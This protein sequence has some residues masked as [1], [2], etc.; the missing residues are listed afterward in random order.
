MILWCMLAFLAFL[1][2]WGCANL[3]HRGVCAI[4][5]PSSKT[6]KDPINHQVHVEQRVFCRF[7]L[8]GNHIIIITH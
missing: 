1:M 5:R 4:H 8:D 7:R 2:L 3:M 6:H